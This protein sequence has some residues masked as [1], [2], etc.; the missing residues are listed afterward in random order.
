MPTQIDFDLQIKNKPYI[1][2]SQY[3]WNFTPPSTQTLV[4]TV[5]STCTFTALPDGINAT[6]SPNKHYIGADASGGHG[7]YLITA[8][9]ETLKTIK[10]TPDFSH[11]AGAWT[12]RSASGGIQ[13]AI[14]ANDGDYIFVPPGDVM[15]DAR[16]VW[17]NRANVTIRGAGKKATTLVFTYASANGFWSDTYGYEI[18]DMRFEGLTSTA[19]QT[20][21]AAI[22]LIGTTPKYSGEADITVTGCE[23]S[24][25][26]DVVNYDCPGGFIRYFNN[27]VRNVQRYGVYHKSSSA[28]AIQICDNYFD[29]EFSPGIIWLE[30]VLG[31]GIIADNWMQAATA[32]IVINGTAGTPV[33]EL[34]ICGNILDNDRLTTVASVVVNG[35]GV[36]GNSSNNIQ[37]LSNYFSSVGYCVLAQNACNLYMNSNKF[38]LRAA[39]PAVSIS[40]TT[41]RN[42]SISN[43]GFWSTGSCYAIQVAATNTI[44]CNIFNN[45]GV[46]SV[47]CAAFI[48]VVGA[49]TN[50]VINGN[51]SGTNYTKLIADV[52]VTGAGQVQCKTN[53]AVNQPILSVTSTNTITL[54]LA[55]EEQLIGLAAGTNTITSMI[56]VTA[57]AGSRRTFVTDGAVS[58]GTTTALDNRIGKAYVSTA[59]GDVITFYKFNDNLWYPSK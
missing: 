13:E 8:V 21:G 27:M 41:T 55:D 48:G 22:S 6:D 42:I 26:Y 35:D 11:A 44:S 14:Y 7:A 3:E 43:N 10:F 31:G 24:N 47:A 49:V 1:T 19:T 34:V 4:A 32:H 20:A 56:G 25:M 39:I 38:Y 28:G 45:T 30:S 46:A 18:H 15:Y 9:N 23:F 33:N 12:L 51:S 16:K 58:W 17:I 5:E 52:G 59:A 50:L 53:A 57:R 29:G 2:S 40:G 37:I 36:E 54:P